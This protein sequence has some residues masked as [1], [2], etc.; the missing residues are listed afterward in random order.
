MTINLNGL[1]GGGGG[2]T[3]LGEI[4]RLYQ[5]FPDDYTRDGQ[6]FLR[7]GFI[8]TSGWDTSLATSVFPA[9]LW[10][11]VTSG[12]GSTTILSV[13]TDGAGVWVAGGGGA[14]RRSTNNGATWS[15]VT[16][17][18]GS[19]SINS[20]AKGQ[21]NVWIAVGQSGTI[22]RAD[23]LTFGIDTGNIVDYVRYL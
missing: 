14:M 4:T 2:G 15:A 23:E 9:G 5:G 19:T 20:V 21:A 8:I 12:F 7:S 6:K 17:G 16:S 10:A 22:T 3:A 13:A 1:G 18:F 11:T